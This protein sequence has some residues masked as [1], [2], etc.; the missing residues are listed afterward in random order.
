[1][2]HQSA[3][4]GFVIDCQ[5][6]DLDAAAAFWS[7]AL[8]AT[9]RPDEDGKYVHLSGAFGGLDL[10]LQ[11]VDHAPR[12]HMDLRSDDI[13]AEAARLE[14]LGARRVGAVQRW[15]VMEA[16]TGHRFCIVRRDASEMG[17]DA[18]TWDGD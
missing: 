14:A 10:L 1:M 18:T 13:E 15:I 9:A 6:D 7:A 4:E 11:A 12:I 3:L 5:V 2:A 17:G 16:P 8:G